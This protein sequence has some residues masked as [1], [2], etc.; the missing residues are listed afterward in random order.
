MLFGSLLMIAD[1]L[2]VGT[3]PHPKSYT[4]TGYLLDSPCRKGWENGLTG[5][6]G[7]LLPPRLSSGL[8]QEYWNGYFKNLVRTESFSS[9]GKK[10]NFFWNIHP[11]REGGYSF[12]RQ[13]CCDRWYFLKNYVLKC[14]KQSSWLPMFFSET[15]RLFFAQ[16]TPPLMMRGYTH[17]ATDN[18]RRSFQIH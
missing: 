2:S 11:A 18:A 10:S 12:Y 16:K 5:V 9:G 1:L 17:F 14:P 3:C 6:K 4:T 7:H 15:T 8:L 13:V